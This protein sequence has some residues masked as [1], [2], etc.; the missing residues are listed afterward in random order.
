MKDNPLAFVFVLGA[1]TFCITMVHAKNPDLAD[2][3][4]QLYVKEIAI[5]NNSTFG[6]LSKLRTL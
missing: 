1:L 6:T 2:E 3:L 5:L 4:A